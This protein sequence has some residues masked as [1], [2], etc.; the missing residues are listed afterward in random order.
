MIASRLGMPISTTHTLVGAVIG[1][2]LARG[3]EALNIGM[4][5]DIIASWIITIPAGALTAVGIYKIL[6][7]I[8]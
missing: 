3:I 8:F 4:T 2:G 5:R 6:A 1:V 7:M